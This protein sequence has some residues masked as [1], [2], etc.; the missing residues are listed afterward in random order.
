MGTLSID[1][2]RLRLHFSRGEKVLGAITRD[3]DVPLSSVTSAQRVDE[4]WSRAVHGLRVGLGLPGFRLLGTWRKRGLRQLV[5]LR[6]AEP[7]LRI[8]LRDERCDE[9]LVSTPDA[10]LLLD[11]LRREGVSVG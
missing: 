5:D 4:G 7:F 6:R 11:R 3:L 2:H 10:D 9:V 1:D 8:R